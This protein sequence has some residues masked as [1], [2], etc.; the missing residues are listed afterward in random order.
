[1]PGAVLHDEA[2]VLLF[3]GPGR[4]EAGFRHNSSRSMSIGS[5]VD[6]RA[7]TEI[8]TPITIATV[9]QS[10]RM[11]NESTI[12]PSGKGV[13]GCIHQSVSKLARQLFD[14]DQ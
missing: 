4:R 11:K 8:R 5:Y 12:V 9:I 3:N 14:W 10:M 6:K 1:L 2:R 7:I 13:D